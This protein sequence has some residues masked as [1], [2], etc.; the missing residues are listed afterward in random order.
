MNES[1]TTPPRRHFT[2]TPALDPVAETCPPSLGRAHVQT[3]GNAIP[4]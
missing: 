3:V 2:G 1:F 4:S